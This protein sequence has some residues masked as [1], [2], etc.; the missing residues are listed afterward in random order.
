MI[1]KSVAR[2]M[3]MMPGVERQIRQASR[4]QS[5]LVQYRPRR[6]GGGCPASSVANPWLEGKHSTIAFYGLREIA[7]GVAILASAIRPPSSGAK[8][9]V[10]H[11]TLFRSVGGF[12]GS[13]HK[14]TVGLAVGHGCDCDGDRR[15]L[16]PDLVR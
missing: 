8:W 6:L 15:D 16:R 10:M 4:P 3:D 13:R 11:W 7:T 12:G 5:R 2:I 9:R 1:I 14:A